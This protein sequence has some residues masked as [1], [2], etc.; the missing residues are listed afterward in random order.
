MREIKL[1]VYENANVS[2]KTVLTILR[3]KQINEE[4]ITCLFITT[5][6]S[7][8]QASKDTLARCTK[9]VVF[10]SGIDATFLHHTQQD[11]SQL[12]K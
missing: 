4:Y 7:W 9:W 10:D 2:R 6:K 12:A 5:S 8:R 1:P 3:C 11:P